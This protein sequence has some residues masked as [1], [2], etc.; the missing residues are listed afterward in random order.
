MKVI[1]KMTYDNFIISGEVNEQLPL[2]N[3]FLKELYPLNTQTGSIFPD[4]EIKAKNNTTVATHGEESLFNNINVSSIDNSMFFNSNSKIEIDSSF[5]D[6]NNFD[7]EIKFKIDEVKD[8]MNILSITNKSNNVLSIDIDSNYRNLI[9]NTNVSMYT[10]ADF[11]SKYMLADCG[12]INNDT[13]YTLKFTKR[14]KVATVHINDSLTKNLLFKDALSYDSISIGNNFKGF[15][16]YISL[17]K[18]RLTYDSEQYIITDKVFN[19]DFTIGFY[20]H[21]DIISTYD[22]ATI[23]NIKFVSN[24]NVVDVYKEDVKLSSAN[25]IEDNKYYI[26]LSCNKEKNKIQIYNLSSHEIVLSLEQNEGISINNIQIINSPYVYDLAI[27]NNY[28][29]DKYILR[30]VQRNFSLNK[31]GN[32]NYN[33]NEED[34]GYRLNNSI[35]VPLSDDLSS[36]C[37]TIANNS[38]DLCRAEQSIKSGIYEAEEIVDL[39][40]LDLVEKIKNEQWDNNLHYNA[41]TVPKWSIGY[42]SSVPNAQIGYHAKWTKEYASEKTISLKF[43]NYNSDFNMSNRLMH[44]ERYITPNELWNKCKA[45][46]KIL[47]LFRSKSSV[48]CNIKMGIYRKL[49]STKSY[50]FSN[51][52]KMI[53]IQDSSWNEYA[54]EV[55]IDEDWDLDSDANLYIYGNITD[56]S[57]CQLKDFYLIK[58]GNKTSIDVIKDNVKRNVNIPLDNLNLSSSNLS[59]IYNTK[60]LSNSKDIT[61]EIEDVSW[62]IKNNKLYLRAINKETDLDITNQYLNEWLTVGLNIASNTATVYLGTRQGIYECILNNL[63]LTINDMEEIVFDSNNCSLYKDLYISS[64]LLSKEIF[65]KHHRTKISYFNGEMRFKSILEELNL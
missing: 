20:W 7:F 14:N 48:P 63:S 33:I 39:L 5:F 31:D 50:S 29:E 27:Y 22:I 32:L 12:T 52:L 56:R 3:N 19:N 49:K 21:P 36:V 30:N 16:E 6:L 62:G 15:V 41:Y 10:E 24:V 4:L 58:N 40:D 46:D 35:Y 18:K 60:I 13:W 51:S 17:Y 47:I 61:N 34:A 59:I 38:K 43:I 54:Y 11:N 55:T 26:S 42:D 1:S 37:K 23:G 45:G 44:I 53:Q 65:E 25:V 2:Y 57:I 9:L 64:N 28:L 8:A